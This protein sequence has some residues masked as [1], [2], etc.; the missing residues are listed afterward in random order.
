MA[1]TAPSVSIL[2][3]V[4]VQI[5]MRSKNDKRTILETLYTKMRKL[6]K[7]CGIRDFALSL[8]YHLNAHDAFIV[9]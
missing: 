1:F 7:S 4:I 6:F 5:E 9:Q 2:S 8:S 3:L